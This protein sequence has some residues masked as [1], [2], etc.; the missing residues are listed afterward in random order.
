[1]KPLQEALN[2]S[3]T[4]NVKQVCIFIFLRAVFPTHDSQLI[5]WFDRFWLPGGKTSNLT[6]KT[7]V[8][9]VTIIYNFIRDTF[10]IPVLRIRSYFGERIAFYFAFLRFILRWVTIPSVLGIVAFSLQVIHFTVCK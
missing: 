10:N 4:N 7:S 2:F 9:W 3:K 1:M 5:A 8:A 6:V